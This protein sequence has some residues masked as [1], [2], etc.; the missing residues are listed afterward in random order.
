MHVAAVTEIHHSLIPALTELRDALDERSKAF[1]GIIKIGRTHLQVISDACRVSV[2]SF[3]PCPGRDPAH[4][5]PRIQWICPASHLR[6][7]TSKGRAAALEPSCS[8]GD[9]R[10]HSKHSECVSRT[11]SH[12][13]APGSQHEEG[14]RREDGSRDIEPDWA[15][16]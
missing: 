7:R 5:R 13:H 12:L 8:G 10:R 16:I 6:Y 9:R 4:A 1:D 15:R 3:H 11:D 2:I 14:I